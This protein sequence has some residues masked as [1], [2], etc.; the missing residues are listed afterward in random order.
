MQDPRTHLAPFV[1]R[2]GHYTRTHNRHLQRHDITFRE[3]LPLDLVLASCSCGAEISATRKGILTFL[4]QHTGSAVRG[5]LPLRSGGY[6]PLTVLRV[7]NSQVPDV[8]DPGK[9]PCGVPIE[10]YF[11]REAERQGLTRRQV[12]IATYQEGKPSFEHEHKRYDPSDNKLRSTGSL[13][14][15]RDCPICDVVFY[16][17][18]VERQT[19]A[20]SAEVER[21]PPWT[22]AEPINWVP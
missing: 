2:R 17:G 6:T 5:D 21:H 12:A 19:V 20:E 18:Q 16:L 7:P 9:W 11:M 14:A 13:D 10:T 4:R 1:I 8:S 3:Y 22:E 15:Q